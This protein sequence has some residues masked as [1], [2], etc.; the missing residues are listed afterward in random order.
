VPFKNLRQ[1]LTLS[2]LE[3]D[4][5]RLQDRYSG[6]DLTPISDI[7]D[8]RPTRVAG[9][10]R[11]MKVVPRAGSPWLEVTVSDGTGEAVAMFSGR[12]AVPGLGPGRSLLLEG[13][14]R[15]DRRRV[16]LF[17]PSYTLLP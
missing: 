15:R 17:N 7:P 10:V 8:R 1:R 13:V 4:N 3:L 12:R 9:E 11:A 14:P 2:V 6:L 16:V 5:A